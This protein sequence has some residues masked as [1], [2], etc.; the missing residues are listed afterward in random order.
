MYE[1]YAD[2]STNNSY[3]IVVNGRILYNWKRW[4]I[5]PV[6]KKMIIK[7]NKIDLITTTYSN[8]FNH[9]IN[10]NGRPKSDCSLL[11]DKQFEQIKQNKIV[12]LKNKTIKKLDDLCILNKFNY[13]I[14]VHVSSK[15]DYSKLIDRLK[16]ADCNLKFISLAAW[17]IK[18]NLH[19]H[20]L[21]NSTLNKDSIDKRLKKL[22]YDSK[23]ITNQ[24]KLIGYLRKNIVVD[25]IGILNSTDAE[26]K[27]KQIEI[28]R[29]KNIL[30]NSKNIDKPI[31]I[32][33]DKDI[34]LKDIKEL[35]NTQYTET[36]KY[37]NLDSKVQIDKFTKIKTD[38]IET[39]S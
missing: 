10:R 15:N 23:I 20:I 5:I 28:L 19:Y 37:N 33:L 2:L 36:I 1:K 14:T 30:S 35:D 39:N 9:V 8:N 38:E 4:Y 3:Y 17:S 31:I 26:L 22:D 13:W 18:S 34:E 24:T 6:S 16:K 27:D 29:Y 21:L 12:Y 32:K 7:N 11:S 25:M